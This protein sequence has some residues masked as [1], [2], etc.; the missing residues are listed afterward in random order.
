MLSILQQPFARLWPD[1]DFSRLFGRV[2]TPK[3]ESIDL[4]A[5]PENLR[6]DLGVLDG[7]SA[8]GERDQEGAYGA[9]RLITSQRPL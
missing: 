6:R 5:L 9:I 3:P 4:Q 1:V 8:R 7:R 2:A